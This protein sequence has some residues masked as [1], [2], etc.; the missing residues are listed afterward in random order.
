[1][2]LQPQLIDPLD[3]VVANLRHDKA[4]H[5]VSMSH[6]AKFRPSS[7]GF[8]N[9]LLRPLTD[10]DIERYRKQRLEAE[11]R[12]GNFVRRDGRWVYEPV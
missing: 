8:D 3:L 5:L 10:R 12:D 9:Q 7:I 2:D 6:Q 11:H 4:P 1:M